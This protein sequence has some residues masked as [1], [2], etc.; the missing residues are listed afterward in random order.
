M[1]MGVGIAAVVGGCSEGDT[2]VASMGEPTAGIVMDGERQRGA[3]ESMVSCLAEAGVVAETREM[4]DGPRHLEVLPAGGGPLWQLCWVDGCDIGGEEGVSPDAARAALME[5][6]E[7]VA[8]RKGQEADLGDA[9]PGD[10]VWLVVDGVDQTDAWIECSHETGYSTPTYLED[11]ATELREKGAL[12]A[13][14]AE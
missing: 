7:L 10:V 3:A 4:N 6:E 14:G 13:A 5:F 11:P 2:G 1:V 8:S 12:A 9:R